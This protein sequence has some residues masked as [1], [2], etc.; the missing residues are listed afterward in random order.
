MLMLR[1]SAFEA[2]TSAAFPDALR[3]VVDRA[4]AA[5]SLMSSA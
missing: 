2:I 1:R 4:N 3:W 5:A